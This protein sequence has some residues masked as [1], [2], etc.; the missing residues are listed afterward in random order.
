M[1]QEQKSKDLDPEANHK[2]GSA[3]KS[4]KITDEVEEPASKKQKT[5]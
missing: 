2:N 1:S 3:S 5:S 4:K